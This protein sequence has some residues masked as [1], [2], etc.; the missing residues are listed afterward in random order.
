MGPC[1]TTHPITNRFASIWIPSETSWDR[2]ANTHS[3][4]IG[5]RVLSQTVIS[6]PMKGIWSH[7]TTTRCTDSTSIAWAV[8]PPTTPWR[9]EVKIRRARTST[10]TFTTT[11]S[12]DW[13]QAA[14]KTA[15][16]SMT[17]G[18]A[19]A[20]VTTFSLFLAPPV[21][22]RVAAEVVA[23][24]VA[25]VIQ[26]GSREVRVR[27]KIRRHHLHFQLLHAPLR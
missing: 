22:Q 14:E 27:P 23:E 5:T 12:I 10:V 20:A 9:P 7:R 3:E 17:L 6:Q 16:L 24:V 4:R 25:I 19:R 15:I 8:S 13:I 2:K 21:A 11:L 1:T 18:R 26:T